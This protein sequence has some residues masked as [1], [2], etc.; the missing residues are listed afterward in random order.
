M[1]LSYLLARSGVSVILLEKHP[2]FFR[3]FRGDTIH[4]STLDI[5]FELNLL[6]EFL[7]L[8]H[9]EID[10]VRLNVDRKLYPVADLSHLKTKCKFVALIPQWDFL[11]FMATR[12]KK[13][14]EFNL[15]LQTEATDLLFEGDRVVGVKA[16]SRNGEVEIRAD[17]VVGTDGRHSLIRDKAGLKS[18]SFGVPIDVLWMRIPRPPNPPENNLAYITQGL[19]MVLIERKDYYQ[20]A[21]L[22]P[23]GEFKQIQEGGLEAFRAK[24]VGIAPFLT[25]TI[26]EIDS[27]DKVKLLTVVIDRLQKWHRPGLLCIGDAAHAMSPA[28]GVGINLAIQDAV[29]TANALA[30]KLREQTST[31][32]DLAAIQERRLKPT[33]TIQAM[34]VLV[35]QQL[36]NTNPSSTKRLAFLLS[37][38][39]FFPFVRHYIAKFIGVGP[40]PEH[41][42]TAPP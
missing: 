17:L 2:D 33:K 26:G 38:V 3:D 22:I 1:M 34:Q 41:V 19:F 18:K 16:S 8:P 40:L 4:P 32:Q 12:A 7:A 36:I 21:Y 14:P 5:L 24:I 25:P 11:N 30:H 31:E 13:F 23:K 39:R 37:V 15:L 29:A 10:F 35:H 9:D 28:G 42:R 6:D 20:T 27:W